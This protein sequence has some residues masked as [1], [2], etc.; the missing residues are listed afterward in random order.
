[1]PGID[2]PPLNLRDE[3]GRALASMSDEAIVD[4]SDDWFG[5]IVDRV[6]EQAG[7]MRVAAVGEYDVERDY[8]T[9]V[10]TRRPE[11]KRR[12]RKF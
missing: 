4:T 10:A 8:L 7:Y 12:R 1:M 5:A 2:K 9:E 11:R 6:C 3:V